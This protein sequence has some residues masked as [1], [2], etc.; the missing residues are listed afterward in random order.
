MIYNYYLSLGSNIEPKILFLRKSIDRLNKVGKVKKKSN[1]YLTQ[2]WGETN[3][4]EFYNAMIEYQSKLAPENLLDAIKDIEYNIGRK[5]RNKWGP[6]EID[7]DIIFCKG[8]VLNK[9]KLNIPHKD[10][11]KRLFILELMCELD[12]TYIVDGTKKTVEYFLKI[13]SD[14]SEI[15]KADLVW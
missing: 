14:K 8:M 12:K 1:I 5:R 3:Q 15:K 11:N 10:F 6:R 2:P 4:P 7:I 9:K 13:C